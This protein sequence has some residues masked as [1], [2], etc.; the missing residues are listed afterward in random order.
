MF[1]GVKKYKNLKKRLIDLIKRIRDLNL[2]LNL[3]K[4]QLI[5]L[6]KKYGSETIKNVKT[7]D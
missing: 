5:V 6:K 3:K 4:D 2:N 7:V 1:K